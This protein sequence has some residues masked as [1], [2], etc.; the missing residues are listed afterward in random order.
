M[1]DKKTLKEKI[2]ELEEEIQDMKEVNLYDSPL[3]VEE[4]REILN[5]LEETLMNLKKQS[6]GSK[7]I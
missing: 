5:K 1:E 2:A 7:K 4:Q 3:S 6:G